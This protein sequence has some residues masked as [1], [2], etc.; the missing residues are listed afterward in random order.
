MS[1]VDAKVE[2]PEPPPAPAMDLSQ[3]DPG[4]RAVSVRACENYAKL[5]AKECVAQAVLAEREFR[6]SAW[7]QAHGFDKY[8]IARFIRTGEIV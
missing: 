7:E 3:F 4:E 1:D 6:A 2:L 8:G 5:Y